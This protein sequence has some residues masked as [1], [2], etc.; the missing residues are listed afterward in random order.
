MTRQLTLSVLLLLC[1]RLIVA[2]DTTALEDKRD[3]LDGFKH[4]SP[5]LEIKRDADTHIIPGK[6]YYSAIPVVGYSM[7]TGFAFGASGNAAFQAS[8]AKMGQIPLTVAYTAKDQ[9]IAYLLPNIWTRNNDLNIA[10]EY[11]F[12]KFP[13]TT[14]GIGE[15]NS[16]RDAIHIDCRMLR[17]YQNVLKKITRN[18]SAGLG[19]ALDYRWK[20]KVLDQSDLST[21]YSQFPLSN[22]SVSSGINYVLQWDSRN[23][24][25][26][27][28]TGE[29]VNVSVRQNRKALGSQN[30]WTS[31]QLDLRKYFH[32]PRN[33]KNVL[34]L[35]S[36]NWI[37]L[38][39]WPPYLDLPST[40]WDNLT[41]TGRGYIQGRF[42][43]MNM[44]YFESEYRFG[45]T[46]N[47]LLGGVVFLNGQSF[48]AVSGHRP[49]KI[50]PGY[51]AGLRIKMNKYSNTNMTVDYGMGNGNSRGFFLG[52]AE[53]F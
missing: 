45:I 23:S 43:G 19:Y 22:K 36:F 50:H 40:G 6:V 31:M 16:L 21:R 52:V 4:I 10:G 20:I 14:Y 11:G 12:M 18:F 48:S 3:I 24:A 1:S 9:A 32:F 15:T 53:M 5:S 25:I 47:G 27:A 37:T 34:A 51:G 35:W 8:N 49:G 41:S 28:Q 30:N 7:Q 38:K 46:K 42:R 39:G 2:Q 26:N 17:I 44:F 29:Y 13:Q 33:S